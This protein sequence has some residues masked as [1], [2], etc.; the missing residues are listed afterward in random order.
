[1]V[2]ISWLVTITCTL[3]FMMHCGIL[4]VHYIGQ[5][6]SMGNPRASCLCPPHCYYC[7]TD[8]KSLLANTLSLTVPKFFIILGKTQ[9]HIITEQAT[10]INPQPSYI[11]SFTNTFTIH[12]YTNTNRIPKSHCTTVHKGHYN[13]PREAVMKISN[14]KHR[15][16]EEIFP[17]NSEVTTTQINALKSSYQA[18]SRN[19]ITS[20]TQLNKI[21]HDWSDTMFEGKQKEEIFNCV[22]QSMLKLKQ[23]FILEF[24]CL[25]FFEWKGHFVL[26]ITVLLHVAWPTSIHGPLSHWKKMCGPLRFVFEYPWYRV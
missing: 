15:N 17:Q 23:H 24:C 21:M 7:V 12:N 1:M 5:R 16:F 8:G 22:I 13:M 3:L 4:W 11:S 20:M 25:L 18:A 14:L 10:W 26:N 6:S 19:L 9:H 2:N